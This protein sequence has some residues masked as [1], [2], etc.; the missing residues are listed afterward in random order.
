[1]VF[2]PMSRCVGSGDGWLAMDDLVLRLVNRL[3]DEEIPLHSFTQRRAWVSKIV[4]APNPKP[5]DF[6]AAAITGAGHISYTT[7]GNSAW[8]EVECLRLAEGDTIID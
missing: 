5:G 6:T 2:S 7:A 4:F 8:N 3:T 1:M